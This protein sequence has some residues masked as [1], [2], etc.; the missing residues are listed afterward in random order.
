MRVGMLTSIGERC[1]IACYTAELVKA[2]RDQIEVEIEVV[3]I[4][5]GRQSDE[6]YVRQA[7]ILNQH[8]VVHIQHEHS[9][10]GGFLPGHSAFWNLRNRIRKPVVITAHTTTSVREMLRPAQ[11]RTAL[12]RVVK[13]GLVRWPGYR[14]S[15]ELKPFAVGRCIVHTEEGRAELIGRGA[16]PAR[17]HVIPAGVPPPIP[18]PTNG[19]AIRKEF[20][21][22]GKRIV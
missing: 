12:R 3:P 21:L 9:F 20:G 8:D 13:E 19:E 10:W 1:G 14:K 16:D 11:A 4:T 2:L 17:I 7:Q 15:V 18:A 22:D 5:P 6:H